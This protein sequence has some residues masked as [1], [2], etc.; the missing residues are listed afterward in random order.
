[1]FKWNSNVYR[2]FENQS[3]ENLFLFQTHKTNTITTKQKITVFLTDFYVFIEWWNQYHTGTFVDRL[4]IVQKHRF[5]TWLIWLKITCGISAKYKQKKHISLRLFLN[6]NGK[7][8]KMLFIVEKPRFACTLNF[9]TLDS[10]GRDFPTFFLIHFCP[11][12]LKCGEANCAETVKCG[13]PKC[14][15]TVKYPDLPDTL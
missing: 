3:H 12:K 2:M 13:D 15:G 14:P 11:K 9:K 1:M 7:I 6:P 4:Q 8:K 10:D 5:D